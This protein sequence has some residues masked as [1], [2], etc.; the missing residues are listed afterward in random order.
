MLQLVIDSIP[1]SVTWWKYD[2]E[3]IKI[4]LYL[5]HSWAEYLLSGSKN[6]PKPQTPFRDFSSESEHSPASSIYLDPKDKLFLSDMTK[7]KS[8]LWANL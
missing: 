8:K 1:N 2:I 4:K 3:Q 6:K 7:K 5:F